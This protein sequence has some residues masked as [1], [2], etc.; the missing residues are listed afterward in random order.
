MHVELQP[1][2]IIEYWDRNLLTR[3]FRDGT[4]NIKKGRGKINYKLKN[5]DI[6]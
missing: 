1:T 6:W 4:V 3:F 2:W 5:M